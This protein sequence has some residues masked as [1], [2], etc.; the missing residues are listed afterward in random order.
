M[1]PKSS[2]TSHTQTCPATLFPQL[3]CEHPAAATLFTRR[4]VNEACA[5]TTAPTYARCSP[6]PIL[7]LPPTHSHAPH[8]PPPTASRV[9]N[10]C[11]TGSFWRRRST[12]SWP[13]TSSSPP[14][15]D[16]Q[17]RVT[18]RV[19]GGVAGAACVITRQLQLNDQLFINGG[20]CLF[21]YCRCFVYFIV[22]TVV[23]HC[24]F[25]YFVYFIVATIVNYCGAACI[26]EL[27]PTSSLHFQN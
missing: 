22:V 5:G 8:L 11:S 21:H 18:E 10:S 26:E 15:C 20:A 3:F 25:R 6:P 19:G 7:K 12:L 16:R 2:P 23:N 9:T 13:Q 14:R 17:R 1:A 27:R 24:L 4:C